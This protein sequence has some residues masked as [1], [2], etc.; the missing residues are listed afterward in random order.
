MALSLRE[1]ARK[2]G[3]RLSHMAENLGI[4]RSY[5]YDLSHGRRFCAPELAEQIS[6]FTRGEVKANTL[7]VPSKRKAK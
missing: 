1:W 6:D 5:I 7:I 4:T 3:V 2:R